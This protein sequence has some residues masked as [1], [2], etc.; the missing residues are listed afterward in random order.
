MLL[1][2]ESGQAYNSANPAARATI[3]QLAQIIAEQAGVHVVFQDPD[4]V[5][6]A[7]RCPIPKQVLS[8]AKVEALGWHGAYTVPE[9]V[10]HTLQVLRECRAQAE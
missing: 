1:R 8:S 5:D 4:A 2:G 7:L 10:A 3:A 6:I 9:G